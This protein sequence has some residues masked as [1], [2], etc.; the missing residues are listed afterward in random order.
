MNQHADHEYLLLTLQHVE[1][2]LKRYPD[3][4][5]LKGQ[6]DA[7]IGAVDRAMSAPPP[8]GPS[9]LMLEA[10]PEAIALKE[11]WALVDRA[12][13]ALGEYFRDRPAIGNDG[14]LDQLAGEAENAMANLGAAISAKLRKLCG[15]ES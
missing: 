8:R 15:V 5:T 4:P 3:H 14:Q 12:R 7:L 1:E 13:D 9:A 6:R 10:G 11:C 2:K